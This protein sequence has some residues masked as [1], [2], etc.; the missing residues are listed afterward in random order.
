MRIKLSPNKLSTSE[1]RRRDFLKTLGVG[2]GCLPLLQASRGSAAGPA[3]K[4]LLIVAST[5]G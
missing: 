2:M 5:E 4:R 3:P 1:L